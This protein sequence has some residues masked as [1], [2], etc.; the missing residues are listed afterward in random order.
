MGLA[1][2]FPVI[3]AIKAQLGDSWS[4]AEGTVPPLGRRGSPE[5]TA[6]SVDE[7]ALHNP[8]NLTIPPSPIK[9]I[10]LLPNY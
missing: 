3:F 2:A 1:C 8:Q 7:R 10:Q 6:L 9:G 5:F 4:I